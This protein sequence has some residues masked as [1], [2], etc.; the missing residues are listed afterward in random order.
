ME[1]ITEPWCGL[2][3]PWTALLMKWQTQSQL[4]HTR[5]LSSSTIHKS[6]PELGLFG[7]TNVEM[8]M[9]LWCTDQE[10]TIPQG[11]I[12]LSLH[13][14]S[15]IDRCAGYLGAWKVSHV[16]FLAELRCSATPWLG[17]RGSSLTPEAYWIDVE[18]DLRLYWCRLGTCCEVSQYTGQI[19]L[20]QAT[21]A[22]FDIISRLTVRI[23][24]HKLSRLEWMHLTKSSK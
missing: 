14:S 17:N 5:L 8:K 11:G 23:L 4:P 15:H 2:V 7:Y 10:T 13:H 21:A 22:S 1:Q 18:D 6:H 12:T 19:F 3:E 20:N 24:S 9:T 16:R